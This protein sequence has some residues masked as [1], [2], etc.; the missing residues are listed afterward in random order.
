VPTRQCVIMACVRMAFRCCLVKLQSQLQSADQLRAKGSPCMHYANSHCRI[1]KS[2][3]GCQL[4][5]LHDM[6]S[7]LC[8]STTNCFYSPLSITFLLQLSETHI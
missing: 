3:A 4:V 5:S 2:R 1:V 6:L 7:L 8:C